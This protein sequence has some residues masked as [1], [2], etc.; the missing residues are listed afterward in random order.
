MFA[1]ERQEM[2]A[3]HIHD[4]LSQ[5]RKLQEFVLAKRLFRGYSGKARI[6][7][8]SVAL[9][10]SAVLSS[11]WVPDTAKAHLLGWGVVLV[12]GVILNYAALVYWFLS[13]SEVRRN[14]RMLKPAIDALP[15][16]G[17]GAVLT[18]AVIMSGQY[19]LLFGVWMCLYGLAQVAYRQ[20]LPTG[21]YIVGVC[22]IMCGAYWLM[23][24]A[25]S[26][27]I[28]WPM[29]M[30][31]FVGEMAGGVILLRNEEKG[32]TDDEAAR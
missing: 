29:G 7:S 30:T 21:I 6:M 31:F 17:V 22:Y 27:V 28:P 3:N 11:A 13:D 14:P 25:M 10:G 2:I 20:S 32:W 19:Y 5:V 18:V 23:S 16:L 4:A 1:L 8:G 26:F 12:V 15:A 24:P 9:I